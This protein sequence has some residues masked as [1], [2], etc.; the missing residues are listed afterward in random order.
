MEANGSLRLNLYD[1]GI[2][3]DGVIRMKAAEPS[4]SSYEQV[5]N[6]RFSE[7]LKVYQQLLDAFDMWHGFE[8]TKIK[9]P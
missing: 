6:R 2:R 4:F 1:F 9:K 8:N 3:V 7:E 5:I